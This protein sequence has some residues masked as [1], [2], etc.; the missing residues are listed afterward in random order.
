MYK[1]IVHVRV[2]CKSIFS[3]DFPPQK[4]SELNANGTWE[5]VILNATGVQ[6]L[7]SP[8][9]ASNTICCLDNLSPRA[10]PGSHSGHLWTS[11]T[12]TH[13]SV[14]DTGLGC[15]R[16]SWNSERPLV[17]WDY[18]TSRPLWE[19]GGRESRTDVEIE[20]AGCRTEMRRSRRD[21]V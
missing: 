15:S 2:W 6:P 11:V 13:Q 19:A 17:T 12:G 10:L 16:P 8:T 9:V 3:P 5:K 7:H 20:A 18:K 1:N 21:G 4:R 14:E